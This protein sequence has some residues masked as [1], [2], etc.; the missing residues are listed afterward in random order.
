MDMG[1]VINAPNAHM[2][3]GF[4]LLSAILNAL[5]GSFQGCIVL[6]ERMKA[7]EGL[8]DSVVVHRI[9]PTIWGRLFG[10][11]RLRKWVGENDV[12]LC[13]GSLPPLFKLRARV[14]LL[15]QNR[16][17]IERRELKGFPLFI[18][19]RIVFERLW[20]AWRKRNVNK[21][22]VQTP[23][24]Q[25]AVW[26]VLGKAAII[27]PFIRDPVGYERAGNYQHNSSTV[28]YDFV[29]V[30]SGEPHKNHHNLILAWSLLAQKGIRPSLCLTLDN[31]RFSDLSTWI[32]R[33]N[34]DFGLNIINL[35][36][37]SNEKVRDLYKEV[38]A[39]IYPSESESLGL[40]L[41]E[42]RCAHIPILASERD[43]V[44]DVI[45]PEQTFDPNSPVS[46]ARAVKRFLS[47]PEHPLPI[48]D[49]QAYLSKI[50]EIALV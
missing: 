35:G 20:F 29:Y 42:A 16:Y 48:M 41:I 34:K 44:R 23:S 50:K 13:F 7:P 6:D 30:A 28:K 21:F 14:L 4:S 3:G 22:I 47:I 39:L 31:T 46:I 9:K 33:Q 36:V 5:D 43:Y 45:D 18:K 40:P 38:S 25:R 10:E 24:M 49:A 11:W 26:E 17:Q 12:V 32:E 8:P 15:I 27:L 37:L 1:L 2:G 19:I